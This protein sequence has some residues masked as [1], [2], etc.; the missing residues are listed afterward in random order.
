MINLD[1]CSFQ[2]PF[3]IKILAIPDI[4]E[5]PQFVKSHLPKTYS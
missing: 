4:W 2:L 3:M 1:M 5:I